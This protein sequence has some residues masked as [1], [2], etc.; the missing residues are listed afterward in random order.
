[1]FNEEYEIV[2]LPP[3]MNEAIIV[4]LLKP[5]K[6]PHKPESYHLI[7]LLTSIVKLLIK[8]ISNCLYKVIGNIIHPDQTGFIPTRSMAL[9]VR[10]SFLNL[11]VPANNMDNRAILLLDTA[12]ALMV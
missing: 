9:N 7:S 2:A 12:K 10:R 4:V 5:G 1:M 6:N 8:V 3:S 11:Q